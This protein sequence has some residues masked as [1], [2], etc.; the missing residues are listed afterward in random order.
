MIARSTFRGFVAAS[1]TAAAIVAASGPAG[2]T[3]VPPSSATIQVSG[4]TITATLTQISTDLAGGTVQCTLL[5]DAA[6]ALSGRDPAPAN[7]TLNIKVPE[8]DH[9]AI[10]Y[11][12]DFPADSDTPSSYPTLACA[13]VN[14]PAGTVESL[15]PDKCYA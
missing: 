7:F 8:G 12:A 13:K 5:V 4:E 9:F 11:C 14:V 6:N 10:T 3:I 15:P 2:A 1:S